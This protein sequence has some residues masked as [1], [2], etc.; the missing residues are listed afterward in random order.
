MHVVVSMAY[1]LI[2]SS[3]CYLE[4]VERLKW[5]PDDPVSAFYYMYRF[6]LNQLD[7]IN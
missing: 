6:V 7:I 2:I 4:P 3:A 5:W 1:N